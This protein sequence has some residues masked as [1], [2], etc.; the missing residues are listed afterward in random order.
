M[1]MERELPTSRVA[2]EPVDRSQETVAY[3]NSAEHWVEKIWWISAL[4]L[5]LL[6]AVPVVTLF[7]RT[8]LTDLIANIG[9]KTVIQAVSVSMK[10][11]LVSV[12]LIFLLGTPLA[13]LMGRHRF[14]YKKALDALI[15]LP[16]VLPPSVAGLALLI[17]F[18]RRGPIGGWLEGLGIEI[19]FSTIAVVIAQIFIAA[20]FYVRSASVGFAAVDGEIEQ[21]ARI[22]GASRWQIFQFLIMPLSRFAILTGIIMSWARAL[23]EFGATM[24]F[25]GNFPGRT[26]TMPTAIYLGFERDLESA[27]TL[28]VILVLISFV[29]LLVIKVLVSHSNPD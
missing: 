7:T 21:A 4:P 3:T 9:L 6:I 11:T 20:P 5:I 10:T 15:D 27:L 18:G 8:S 2:G 13:Y 24:I 14:R 16:L 19:A 17:T 25:A 29:S 1:K 23:G 28:S 12:G 26:Q 22:D